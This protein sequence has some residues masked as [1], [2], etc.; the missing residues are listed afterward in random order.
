MKIEK[1]ISVKAIVKISAVM[2]ICSFV[3]FGCD[4]TD[5]SSTK[6]ADATPDK[7][8]VTKVTKEVAEPAATDVAEKTDAVKP[9]KPAEAVPGKT[10]EDKLVVTINGKDFRRSDLDP[11]IL[12]I[13]AKRFRTKTVEPDMLEKYRSRYMPQVTATLVRSILMKADAKK[14]K[15][16][17]GDKEVDAKLDEMVQLYLKSR[18]ITRQELDQEIQSKEKMTLE[19]YLAGM[20]SD[21]KFR[22]TMLAEKIMHQKFAGELKVTAKEIEKYYKDNKQRFI[23][24]EMVQASHILIDTRKMKTDEEKAAARKKIEDIL[25]EVKKPDA[26]FAELA[27][28]YSD[29]PSKAKGGDL[30][31]FPLKGVHAGKRA[32]V[33]EF[34]NVAF[35]MEV[36]Q[37]SDIV[38]TQFGYHIIKVTGKKPAKDVPFEE[39]KE[40]I[41]VFLTKNKRIEVDRKYYDELK[42]NAKIIY[43]DRKKPEKVDAAKSMPRPMPKPVPKPKQTQ[44]A[45]PKAK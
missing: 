12:A 5:V 34:G 19:E 10:V 37:I 35:A 11:D 25:V 18:S 23:Q 24:P 42:K 8:T 31:F 13:L 44:P 41:N 16:T 4:D 38:D 15:I 20:K 3:F 28:K 30:D 17:V 14:M 21:P 9:P 2:V 1:G 43:H 26:D 27:K 22:E 6:P 40:K 39:V 7:A 36:G 33:P 29:C 45:Q 32:M